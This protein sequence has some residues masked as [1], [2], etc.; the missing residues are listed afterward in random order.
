MYIRTHPAL[1]ACMHASCL[2]YMSLTPLLGVMI[3]P[4]GTENVG[5]L[6]PPL[7]LLLLFLHPS[8]CHVTTHHTTITASEEVNDR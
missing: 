2:F 5:L 8:K 3:L 6:A 1:H 7:L 4:E